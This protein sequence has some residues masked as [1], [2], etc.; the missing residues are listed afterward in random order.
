VRL[1]LLPALAVTWT[2]P[3]A[4]VQDRMTGAV[5]VQDGAA[6]TGVPAVV[7]L[8]LLWGWSITALV[9]RTRRG[10]R[11]GEAASAA[12]LGGLAC[13]LLLTGH[14]WLPT[15]DR[16]QALLP[17]FGP[18]TLLALLDALL[19]R[20][21]AGAEAGVRAGLGA[22][23]VA[24]GLF[25]S[26]ALFADEAGGPALIVLAM[27]LGPL[28]FLGGRTDAAAR[29][30]LDGLITLGG[31]GAGFAPTMQRWL[32]TVP[33]TVAGLEPSAIAWSVLAALVVLTG[34]SGL[35]APFAPEDERPAPVPP[36]TAT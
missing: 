19:Q 1:V 10:M 27:S 31:L 32:T 18:L 17:V 13:A 16:A 6:R 34:A 33:D 15:A 5:Y 29:R 25:S 23:R 9:A 36:A 30:S 8:V 3:W 26:A 35:F 2:L 21:Q 11:T 14:P 20:A 28:A 4:E 24:A 12:L 22:V 7:A